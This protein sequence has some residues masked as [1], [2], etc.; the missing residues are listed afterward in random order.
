[1]QNCISSLLKGIWRWPQGRR[2]PAACG[3]GG[4][5]GDRA[6]EE[7]VLHCHGPWT[8]AGG[9]RW[10]LGEQQRWGARRG[11]GRAGPLLTSGGAP[12]RTSLLT[13]G[14]AGRREL[15]RRLCL[16]PPRGGRVD[17]GRA[18]EGR[19]GRSSAVSGGAGGAEE[20]A[21]AA[22]ASR[23]EWRDVRAEQRW[24]H[25]VGAGRRSQ[26]SRGGRCVCLCD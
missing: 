10:A 11:G 2:R 19:G 12:L 17:P 25:C 3:R 5:G 24:P 4:G 8:G 26:S 13:S 20:H 14:S 18:R 16:G 6:G 7:D 22:A 1:M 9:G 15:R 21:R 23:S